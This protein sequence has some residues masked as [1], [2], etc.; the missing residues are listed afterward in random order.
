MANIPLL[1]GPAGVTEIRD[2]TNKLIKQINDA[3]TAQDEIFEAGTQPNKIDAT[4]PPDANDDS[5]DTGGN[6]AFEVGSMWIDTTASPHEIYRCVDATPTAAVWLNTTLEIGDLGTIVTQ[7]AN[8]VAITGGSVTG[9]TDIAVADGGTGASTAADARTNLDVDQ[10]GTDNSTDVTLSG[11]PD[12]ITLSGQDIVRG[13]IDLT[14]DVTG[15]LPVA[16]GGTGSST[17]AD[18]RTALG[19]AIGSDV[20]AWSADLDAVTGTNTGD[21]SD[22]E[23]KTAYENNADTNAFTDAEQSKLGGIEALA[24]VTDAVNVEAAGALMDSEVDADIKTLSL[25]ASTTISTF[26]ASLVDDADAATAR[27]T[28]DVDQAGTDNST[29]VTIAA[30]LDYVTILAQELTLGSVDLT[31]D[32]T[33]NLPVTNLGSGTGAS[34]STFWRGDGTWSDPLDTPLL[35]DGKDSVRQASAGSVADLSDVTVA[36]FDG[37]AQGITLVEGDR[38]LVKDTASIDGIEAL[39]AKRN[40]IYI[41]GTVTTGKAPLTRAT[42]ADT[43]AEMTSGVFVFVDEGTHAD[44]GWLLSTNDPIT[45]DTT[46]LTFVKFTTANLAGTAD[47]VTISGGVV[48]IASTY[49]GQTTITTLGTITTGTWNGTDIAVADGGTGASTAADARTNLGVAIGT[50][51]QAYDAELAALAGL[52]SAADKGIQFTG[53][54]TAATYDLT[55]FALT[56]LDDADAATAR[57]TLDVDQAGT[58]NSTDVTLSG[59]GTYIGLTGQDIQVDPIAVSDLE[60]GTDGE[61]ITWDA[62]GNPATVA[63][64]TSGQVLTSNG[65]GAAPTFQAASGGLN[66]IVDDSSPQLGGALDAQSNNI[67]SVGKLGIGT[68][69]IPHGAIGGGI[70][71]LDGLD[72]NIAGPHIQTTTAADDY[73]LLQILSYSHDNINFVMDAYYDG[74][75]RSSDVG[76]NAVITKLNDAWQLWYDSGVAQGAAVAWNTAFSVDLTNG[77]TAFKS[78]SYFTPTTLPAI[79]ADVTTNGNFAGDSGW[80]KGTG[81]TIGGA[82]ADCSGVQT[83]NSDIQQAAS[84]TSGRLYRVTYNITSYT[85]GKITPVIGGTVGTTTQNRAVPEIQHIIAGGD[86]QVRLRADVDFVGSVDYITVQDVSIAWDLQLNQVCEVT[87]AGNRQMLNPTNINSGAY[88]TLRVIQDATGGR[89]LIWGSDYVFPNGVAPN[90]TATGNAVDVLVFQARG[91]KMHLVDISNK[92]AQENEYTRQQVAKRVTTAAGSNQILFPTFN[93]DLFDKGTGWSVSGDVGICSGAQ[94]G[95]TDIAAVYPNTKANYSY[96]VVFDVLNYVAGNVRPIIGA[97]GFNPGVGGTAGTNRAANG[98]WSETIVAP[99]GAGKF[100]LRGDL[101]FNGQV[102]NFYAYQLNIEWDL[103]LAQ[104][105]TV[106]LSQDNMIFEAPTNMKDGGTYVMF[107]KQ[108]ATGSRTVTWNSV[109]KWPDGTAPTLSTTAN[110]IDIITFVSDGASMFGVTQKKFS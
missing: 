5:A 107:L 19:V 17:A 40:G 42:D 94:T 98:T 110:A 18:A 78:A 20:Q 34:S 100:G 25:P 64:G 56:L 104:T 7:D 52:T 82:T 38:V 47:R 63:V 1:E 2:A 28:L 10:A 48:D 27:T 109:F 86:G 53:S 66:D 87:L 59:T 24:D 105:T 60:T 51:V 83:G 81:W 92:K 15:D 71:A 62:S 76:S 69:T 33:G 61:L 29:D 31:T 74:V 91:T 99:A 14:T 37:A 4:A 23:V 77:T 43:N 90:L 57:T 97:V 9:V 8:N 75:W 49:V 22:A 26:G 45:L 88:Y 85:A 6:G 96:R 35:K 106:T 95:N 54:G 32:I 79:G 13:Q 101:N 89:T 36:D 65:A 80:T 93:F 12:Y 39:D 73:P 58:D 30:G 11:T 16:E 50:D 44:T 84:L 103:R 70:L 21:M 108:D 41:V 55:A 3:N 72:N 102:D 68:A 67:T 46:G